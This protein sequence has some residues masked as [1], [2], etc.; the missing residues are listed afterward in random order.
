MKRKNLIIAILPFLFGL[1]FL[2]S[3]EEDIPEISVFGAFSDPTV[4]APSNASLIKITGTTTE[5]K[6]ATTD[7]DGD[8][9]LC[10]VFFGTAED[11]VLYKAGHTGLSL[12]VPVAEGK[13][14]YWYVKMYDANKV[15]TTSE[16]WHFSVAV[17]YDINNFV[18]LF[19]C[20]E[21]GY[22]HYDCNFKKI[23][24]T[25]VENDNFWDNG[26]AVQ[27]VFDDYGNVKITP[28]SYFVKGATPDKDVTYDITGSGKFD[29]KAKS[30]YTD[31][32]V[33]NHATGA[34]VDH[35]VHTFVKK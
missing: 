17:A 2:Q 14:Y 3:C 15:M 20:D 23:S 8:A 34:T 12:T 27:Y 35:N 21:P 7:P 19:D 22:K 18:G 29:N 26:W 16:T 1:F 31:Y 4:V 28:V 10:D 6:W 9:P 33:K 13:S 5:L 30:F 11:P 32:T 24:A 25:T